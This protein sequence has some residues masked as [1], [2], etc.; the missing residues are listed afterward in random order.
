MSLSELEQTVLRMLIILNENGRKNVD[1]NI[2]KLVSLL[3]ITNKIAFR[4]TGRLNYK[5][6]RVYSKI[7]NGRRQNKN[8]SQNRKLFFS[9]KYIVNILQRKQF[10]LWL[11]LGDIIKDKSLE[12]LLDCQKMVHLHKFTR[13]SS[14]C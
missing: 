13:N 8:E 5:I 7:W 1:K 10:L 6:I 14:F 4:L 2:T 3:S 12:R 9:P 11:H